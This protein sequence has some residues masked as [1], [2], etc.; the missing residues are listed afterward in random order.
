[1]LDFPRYILE[2]THN[3]TGRGWVFETIND[4]QREPRQLVSSCLLVIQTEAK[5]AF[6]A[7]PTRVCDPEQR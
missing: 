6:A 4:W 1:M 7:Q 3:F 5:V 2:R